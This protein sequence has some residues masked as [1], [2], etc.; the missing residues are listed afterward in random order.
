MNQQHHQMVLEKTHSSKAEEWVCPNCGRRLLINWE[1]K[2]EKTI[3]EAGDEYAIHSGGKGGLRIGLMQSRP[4][5]NTIVEKE[6]VAPDEDPSLAPWLE[7]LEKRDF[8][9]LWGDEAG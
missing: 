9:S 6:S 4:T 7:W 3:L 8:E 1:P 2:F 5:N